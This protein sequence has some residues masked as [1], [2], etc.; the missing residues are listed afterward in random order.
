M[1][2]ITFVVGVP[3]VALVIACGAAEAGR[4]I[5]PKDRP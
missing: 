4:L 5:P 3:V 2:W 1:D